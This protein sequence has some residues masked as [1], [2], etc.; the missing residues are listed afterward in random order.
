MFFSFVPEMFGF[1][2]TMVHMVTKI[3]QLNNATLG[4]LKILDF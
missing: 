1:F 2:T 4:S 3:A